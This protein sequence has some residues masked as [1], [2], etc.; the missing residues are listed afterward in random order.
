MNYTL[1]EVC[2]YIDELTD[3]KGSD[4]FQKPY[5]LKT[6]QTATYDFLRERTPVIEATQQVTQDLQKLMLTTKETVTDN[7][8]NPYT[9]ICQVPET[10]FYLFRVLPLFKGGV[11]SRKPRLIRH[12]NRD[13]LKSDPHNRPTVEY[14]M[15]V[16]YNDY[17]EIDSGINEK[18]LSAYL[19]FLKH[20]TF[21]DVGTGGATRI[22]D[23]PGA[24]IE[25]IIIKTIEILLGSKEDPRTMIATRREQTFGN[26]NQ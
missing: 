12:G 16:Q 21:A 19:T 7:P 24:V 11:T 15:S 3:K 25:D 14:A 22:V 5:V 26:I 8:D 10:C 1:D 20:P 6:F 13:A 18:A 4:L 9:V 23:L 2:D 17:V